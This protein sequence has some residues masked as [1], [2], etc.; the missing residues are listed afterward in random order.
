MMSLL[1]FPCHCS[2]QCKDNIKYI[3]EMTITWPKFYVLK[4][5]NSQDNLLFL[6]SVLRDIKKILYTNESSYLDITSSS[7]GNLACVA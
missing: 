1:Y 3:E 2:N 6:K 4:K 7:F 5:D